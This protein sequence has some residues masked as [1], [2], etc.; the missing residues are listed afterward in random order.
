MLQ[1]ENLLRWTLRLEPWKLWQ[2]FCEARGLDPGAHAS[3]T[4]RLKKNF[5][6]DP[7]HGR[8]RFLNIRA[9]KTPLRAV[10]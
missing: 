7:N 6:H 8:L 4:R 5:P 3:F 1:A 2:T 9:K 10:S